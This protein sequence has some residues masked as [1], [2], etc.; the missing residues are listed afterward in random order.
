M[1][2][3]GSTELLAGAALA[4]GARDVAGWSKAE[5]A[6][7]VRAQRPDPGTVAKLLCAI[8]TGEDPLGDAFC[9]L[10][11]PVERRPQGA[12]YTPEPLVRA[13][14][15]WCK[16]LH[17]PTRVVDPGAGS[18]RFLARAG[19]LFTKAALIGIELDPLAALL[20]RANI[21][22]LGLS[23]RARV[24]VA[25][26]RAVQLAPITGR[27]LFV[28]NP[29]YV[30]HHQIAQEWKTWLVERATARKLDA[31]QLAG[32]HAYFFLATADFAKAGDFGAFVTSAEWLDVNYGKLVRDL[33]LGDLGGC[34]LHVVE[35][36]A[37][38]FPDAATTAAITCFEVGQK[39][40]SIRLRRV[41]SLADLGNLQGGRLVRRERLESAVRWTPLTRAGRK[42]PEGYIELGELCRVHRGQVTGA[43]AVW[44]TEAAA[45]VD[46]PAEV[47]LP[48]VT[49]AR[50]LFS[51]E[52]RILTDPTALKRVIDLPVD[53]DVFS[54]AERRQVDRFLRQ[55]KS[56]G[57]HEGYVARNRK[58]WWAVGLRAPAPILA[59]YMARRPPAF[60]RNAAEARHIN[61]AHGLYPREP[62]PDG[63][64]AALADHLNRSTSL[65]SGRTY[66]G[67]LT[68]FEPR[69]MERLLVP[70]PTLLR[71]AA[72]QRELPL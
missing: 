50:E 66:A 1:R 15:A 37:A 24:T 63:T 70:G 22:A 56:R 61:I 64:L 67:G 17:T 11:S 26:Y 25:D 28:G 29:P 20:A 35:P 68:K 72:A 14:L 57:A 40:K 36:K 13:M 58:A 23:S 8:R 33:F 52:N 45:A 21:A 32:L 62:I 71:D 44:V 4:L 47:L 34:G 3:I 6:L 42:G 39:P 2:P 30:R 18:A 19:S 69:E 55:A 51:A 7:A 10:R 43:N 65:A 41:A 60:V 49:R 5:D 31:S 46:L 12:V 38:P 48:A 9:Q 54:S 59:T 16:T 27:T 53:L